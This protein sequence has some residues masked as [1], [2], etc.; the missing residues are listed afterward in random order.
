MPVP[1]AVTYAAPPNRYHVEMPGYFYE[2]GV[3]ERLSASRADDALGGH[4]IAHCRIPAF[5]VMTSGTSFTCDITGGPKPM[6]IAMRTADKG[7]VDFGPLPGGAVSETA[8]E[9]AVYAEHAAGKRT[10]VAGPTVAS[11]I[12]RILGE[13]MQSEPSKPTV[14]GHAHCPPALD[15]TGVRTAQCYVEV[16]GQRLREV[17]SIRGSGYH[18]EPLDAL[19]DMRRVEQTQQQSIDATLASRGSQQRVLVKC[20]GALRV[21]P[22][23][24]DFTC[25]ALVGAQRA[26]LVV[27]VV[28]T[29]GDVQS[30]LVFPGSPP[31][32]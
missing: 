8:A 23:P 12:D 16:G 10:I 30:K 18:M 5:A 7:Q 4:H 25:D 24:G 1:V 21:V 3:I 32:P 9:R 28:D 26:E 14:V 31:P 29:R 2:R 22:A 13:M 27:H 19:V 6:S 15:L 20:P 11:M 17:V